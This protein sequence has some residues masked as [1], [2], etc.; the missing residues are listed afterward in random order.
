MYVHTVQSKKP[1]RSYQRWEGGVSRVAGPGSGRLF[2]PRPL[3]GLRWLPPLC[4]RVVRASV[5]PG[6]PEAPHPVGSEPLPH[7]VPQ[8][9]TSTSTYGHAGCWDI[10]STDVINCLSSIG[11]VLFLKQ[12]SRGIYLVWCRVSLGASLVLQTKTKFYSLK[13]K[14]QSKKSLT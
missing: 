5:R 6:A 8:R 13:K 9:S 14:K 2:L 11:K 4:P 1:A 7:V 12:E 3:V 10:V